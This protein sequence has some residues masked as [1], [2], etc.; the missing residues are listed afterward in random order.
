MVVIDLAGIATIGT[1][2]KIRDRILVSAEYQSIYGEHFTAST[3]AA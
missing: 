2:L 1:A 3:A